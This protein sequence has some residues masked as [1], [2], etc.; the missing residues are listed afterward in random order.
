MEPLLHY[1]LHERALALIYKIGLP[2]KRLLGKEHQL[3][4]IHR[5]L[6]YPGLFLILLK[7]FIDIMK[8]PEHVI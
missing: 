1:H 3:E 7:R 6:G 2:T 4:N 5:Q 8:I